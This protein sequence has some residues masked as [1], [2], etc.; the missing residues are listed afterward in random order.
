M[1]SREVIMLLD[2]WLY[3]LLEEDQSWETRCEVAARL[4]DAGR[5]AEADLVLS[6]LPLMIE[7]KPY[8]VLPYLI[9]VEN[10]EVRA[11]LPDEV[12]KG[13][14]CLPDRP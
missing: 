12:A 13:L 6:D 2:D 5:E 9:G 11:A 8:T 7:Q 14:A 10:Y 3:R 1:T 4:H